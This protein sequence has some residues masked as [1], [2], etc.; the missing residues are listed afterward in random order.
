MEDIQTRR[1]QVWTCCIGAIW[2]GTIIA[3]VKF[4]RLD[5]WE[6]FWSRVDETPKED[7]DE[8]CELC[9]PHCVI[10]EFDDGKRGIEYEIVE[11]KG[12]KT[13]CVLKTKDNFQGKRG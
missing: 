2:I 9:S 12:I 13:C 7:G 10:W 3:S 1:D 6:G 5:I 4:C 11:Q 8:V